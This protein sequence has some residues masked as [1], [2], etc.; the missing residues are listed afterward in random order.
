[1]SEILEKWRGVCA[2][3]NLNRAGKIDLESSRLEPAPARRLESP[4]P[5]TLFSR[6]QWKL[7]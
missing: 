1:M 6:Q 2:Q 3:E 4:L 7:A 5:A